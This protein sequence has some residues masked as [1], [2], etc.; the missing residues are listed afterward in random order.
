[1][2][3]ESLVTILTPLR[4]QAENMARGL[5]PLTPS[6]AAL[7]ALPQVPEAVRLAD[8]LRS[9]QAAAWTLASGLVETIEAARALGHRFARHSG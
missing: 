8:G 6:I 2:D 1:M 4:I 9:L 7:E 3:T 5:E